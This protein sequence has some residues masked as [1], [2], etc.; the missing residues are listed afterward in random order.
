LYIPL[1]IFIYNIFIIIQIPFFILLY[2][3]FINK[4]FIETIDPVPFI[5][6]LMPVFVNRYSQPE[7]IEPSEEIRLATVELILKICNISKREITPF[8]KDIVCILDRTLQ[9]PYP[10]VKKISCKIIISLVENAERQ[11][12]YFGERI[13]KSLA[14]TLQ[15]KHSSVR[16]IALQVM[17]IIFFII[18]Y[19]LNNIKNS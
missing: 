3:I 12:S 14:P 8:V 4:R 2:F 13:T 17:S 19:I 15:H 10:E 7:I 6:Y 11:V 18:Y 1:F 5:S 9:D 16:I